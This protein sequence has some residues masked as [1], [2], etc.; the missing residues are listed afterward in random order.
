L[1][2]SFPFLEEPIRD[3]SDDIGDPGCAQQLAVLGALVAVSFG[4]LDRE[5]TA[6]RIGSA[7]IYT[8]TVLSDPSDEGIRVSL[9]ELPP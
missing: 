2:L 8:R 9:R 5:Q 6:G 4:R 1:P 3:V 7:A